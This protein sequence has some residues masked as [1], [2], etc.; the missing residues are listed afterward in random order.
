MYSQ[1]SDPSFRCCNDLVFFNHR[2][3]AVNI[4]FKEKKK[5][6]KLADPLILFWW[7]APFFFF[8]GLMFIVG[9]HLP[10]ISRKADWLEVNH[11]RSCKIK[12]KLRHTKKQLKNS[13]KYQQKQE[14]D[15]SYYYMTYK[16]F[17]RN[18]ACSRLAGLASLEVI[19]WVKSSLLLFSETKHLGKCFDHCYEVFAI[20]SC[21]ESHA[22]N[23]AG[24]DTACAI[25][26]QMQ[27]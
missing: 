17:F 13:W 20:W 18:T 2:D 10:H 24:G 5:K 27:E 26:P 6:K 14:K 8:L 21:G 19:L 4:I 15:I 16:Q 11:L 3:D 12:I 23:I 9:L 25:I 7:S 22:Q 1:P